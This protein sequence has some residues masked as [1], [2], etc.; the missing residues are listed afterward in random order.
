MLNN[1]IFRW[2][3]LVLFKDFWRIL[4]N[5]EKENLNAKLSDISG[6]LKLLESYWSQGVRTHHVLHGFD[7]IADTKYMEQDIYTEI[8][9]QHIMTKSKIKD[10]LK[11]KKLSRI[12]KH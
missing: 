2:V 1:W 4:K 8:E 9:N 5:L 3:K 10:L 11:N 12:S 7:H 6:W